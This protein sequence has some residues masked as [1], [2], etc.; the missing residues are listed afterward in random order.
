MRSQAFKLLV[1][2]SKSILYI[3]SANFPRAV[4]VRGMAEH[5]HVH[6]I[7]PCSRLRVGVVVVAALATCLGEPLSPGK[8]AWAAA[9][10][11]LGTSTLFF[12]NE[13]SWSVK[14]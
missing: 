11:S 13:E 10:T 2:R 14:L 1:Q 5:V 9:K 7:V 8:V 4:I 6:A 12:R 3:L